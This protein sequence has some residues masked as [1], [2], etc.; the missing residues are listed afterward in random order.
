MKKYV[1]IFVFVCILISVFPIVVFSAETNTE[2]EQ[3][4]SSQETM[5]Y[6]SSYG[7]E[8]YYSNGESITISFVAL[9]TIEIERFDYLA[10][11]FQVIDISIDN[12]DR[13]RINLELTC[14]NENSECSIEINVLL[15]NEA[16]IDSFVYA[17]NNEFGTFISPYSIEN[18]QERYYQYA[19][20]NGI[21]TE[22]EAFELYTIANSNRDC[23]VMCIETNVRNVSA[24]ANVMST[25][26]E[27]ATYRGYLRWQDDNNVLHPLRRVKVEIYSKEGIISTLLGTQST[28][29]EGYFEFDIPSD[30]KVYLK[31]YAGDDNAKVKT[32]ILGVD[33]CHE[34]ELTA[35]LGA[36]T[37]VTYFHTSMIST[38][39]GKAFQI[40]QAILT[41]RDYAAEMMGESPSN[42]AVWYPY[43]WEEETGYDPNNTDICFYQ[44]LLKRIAIVGDAPAPGFPEAYASWDMIMHE[45]GH[46]IQQDINISNSPGGGHVINA[47]MSEHYKKHYLDDCFDSCGSWSTSCIINNMFN[48]PSTLVPESECKYMGAATAWTEGWATAFSIVAQEYFAEYLL[49][50]DTVNDARY[51]AYNGVDTNLNLHSFSGS[52]SKELEVQAFLYDMYDADSSVESFDTLALNHQNMWDYYSVSEAKTL[53]EFCEYIKNND[54]YKYR[55]SSLGKLLNEYDLSTTKPILSSVGFDCPT[56]EFIWDE[57]NPTGFY[58]ARKFS[59]NFYDSSYNLIGSTDPQVVSLDSIGKGTISINESLWQ[60]VLNLDSSFYVSVTMG[61]YDGDVNNSGSDYYITEYDSEYTRY[62]LSSLYENIQYNGETSNTLD[63][64]DFYWYKFI[65]PASEEY[66]FETSGTMDTYGELFSDLA[67]GH[68]ITNRLT[69]NDDAGEGS[70]FK[71]THSLNKG[72]VV[73]LRVRGYNW[74]KTGDFTLTISSTNHVHDY[75]YSYSQYTNFLHKSYCCCGEYIE[76]GHS[77]FIDSTL[78]R[79]RHCGYS[80]GGLIIPV[81]KASFDE[82][83]TNCYGEISLVIYE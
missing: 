14:P 26:T 65:A 46:H 72:D 48:L 25:E 70:N 12:E 62:Y 18:A 33:Y 16:S 35:T 77:L 76:E 34:S 55:L 61:E 28:D 6:L 44:P 2:Q 64:G 23:E 10:Q 8:N 40:S 49:N 69:Y 82:D 75:T 24:T 5:Y 50:I 80:S 13:S 11:G 68:S 17:V 52:E 1:S 21:I 58:N 39:L 74:T 81:I 19:I 20:E 51:T 32:G 83:E 71:I 30:I 4:N 45:Y 9:P 73:Y 29:N 53:Y 57:P 15:A 43:D 66:V 7:L 63:T 31:I 22:N 54:S 38:D 56:I 67:V 79:C 42:V 59:V 78:S 37:V 36:G 41:A 27:G 47:D 60:S 3:S